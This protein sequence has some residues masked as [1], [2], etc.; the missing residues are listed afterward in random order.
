MVLLIELKIFLP[1]SALV[2]FYNSF[3]LSHLNYSLNACGNA[4]ATA[5]SSLFK[6]QKRAIRNITMSE[7]R[8]HTKPIYNSLNTLTLYDL[9]NYQLVIFM[10]KFHHNMLPISFDHYFTTNAHYHNHNTRA[11]DSLHLYYSRTTLN[12]SQIRTVGV[13]FW[14]NLPNGITLS[15]NT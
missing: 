3:I 4:H 9:Y 15:P 1:L 2:T 13:H 10:H 6:L 5:L 11:I 7:Y 12:Q 8:A 14:N